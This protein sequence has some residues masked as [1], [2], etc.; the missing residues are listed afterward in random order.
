MRRLV[1]HLL[2]LSLVACFASRGHA[3]DEALAETP[4]ADEPRSDLRVAVH[5]F[6]SQGFMWST[7]NNYLTRSSRG[8]FEL[9]EAGINFTAQ[10]TSRFRVGLQIF[11]RDLGPIGN[12]TPQF[13]WFYLDYRFADEFGIRAGRTKLPFGLY[14]EFADIDPAYTPVLL[15]Q[16][17]YPSA[18]RDFLL[19]QTGSELYGRIGLGAL[20]AL[21]YRLYGGTIFLDTPRN[22][23][24]S[25]LEVTNVRVPYVAGGRLMWETPL[26]G[27]RAGTSI[28]TLRIDTHYLVGSTVP[29]VI[30]FPIT[31]LLG[32]L[33]YASGN[34]LLAAEYS[35]WRGE[36]RSD[37]PA[38]FPT[39]RVTNERYYVLG[40]YRL[41]SFFQAG[42][43][44]AG[45]YAD[46][47]DRSG[48]DAY[49]HDVA[50]TL[51]FD[52]HANLVLKL[53]GHLI[54]GTGLLEPSLN[55]GAMR[56]EMA[57]SWGL[58][59]VKTTAVF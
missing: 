19:A 4:I 26:P 42:M 44:Y 33:E 22:T 55:G 12:Y 23:P 37:M 50:W 34:L 47:D 14:N 1:S 36:L 25:P 40:T 29:L 2:L 28:Q 38:L 9:S 53:E 46:T 35:R 18:N 58:F 27:L 43:Y 30:E 13:D 45:Y 7:A 24:G 15:P 52:V 39:V 11:A 17:V 54:R 41:A 51:R 56:S 20:G 59:L 31:V 16:S 6:V 21:E 3:Q 10:L 48:R 49:Q 32:S 8:S 57:R 5:G